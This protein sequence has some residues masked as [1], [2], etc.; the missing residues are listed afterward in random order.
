MPLILH[1]FL[2]PEG[3]IAV[4]EIEE[5]TLELFERIELT[6]VEKQEVSKMSVQRKKEWVAARWLIHK[7]SGRTQRGKCLK[8]EY[9]KPYLENSPFNISISHSQ[10]KVAV[11]AAPY[12]VGIDIQKLVDKM[13]RLSVKFLSDTEAKW[14]CNL[15]DLHVIWGA[16][17]AM[18]K[19]WGKKGIDFKQ[20]MEVEQ[21]SWEHNRIE[22]EGS[23]SKGSVSM[24]FSITAQQVEDFILVRAIEKNRI[25]L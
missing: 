10:D 12:H 23:L 8:D 21:F 18:Y 5:E 9:G 4:W 11:I 15:K 22:T 13:R 1:D 3:E 2:Y 16:K 17:E 25:V 14:K 20:D 6:A 24:R 7:L 19:A